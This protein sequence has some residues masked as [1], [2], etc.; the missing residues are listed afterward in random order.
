[1]AMFSDRK[2]TPGVHTNKNMNCHMLIDA[3]KK[4]HR[5]TLSAQFPLRPK[6]QTGRICS[7]LADI[8][9]GFSKIKGHTRLG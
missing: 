4:Y 7:K 5:S 2:A 9:A 1:M 8:Y 6:L 3:R